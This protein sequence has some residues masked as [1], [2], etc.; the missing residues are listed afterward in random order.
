MLVR[1]LRE[2][3]ASVTGRGITRNIVDCY[4]NILNNY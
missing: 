1:W 2:L 4:E 3:L